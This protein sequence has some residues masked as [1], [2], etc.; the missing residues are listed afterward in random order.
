MISATFLFTKKQYDDDFHR[1]DGLIEAGVASHPEFRGKDSWTNEEKGLTCVVYYF[2]TRAGLEALRTMAVHREAKAGTPNGTP[3]TTWSSP[4]WW[5][6]TVT[7]PS[8]TRRR[9]IS[10]ANCQP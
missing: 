1:L 2:D 10:T 4:R 6:R 5:N 3:A 7:G 9:T 8:I